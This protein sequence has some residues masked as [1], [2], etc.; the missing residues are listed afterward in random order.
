MTT[1]DEP[2]LDTHVSGEGQSDSRLVHRLTAAVPAAQ[3][4]PRVP[5]RVYSV[6]S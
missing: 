5:P 3:L 6:E 2:V 1:P 4:L